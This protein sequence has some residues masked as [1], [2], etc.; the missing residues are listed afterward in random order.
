M[1]QKKKMALSLSLVAMLFAGCGTIVDESSEDVD[2]GKRDINTPIENT[3]VNN[4]PIATSQKIT[5][6]EDGSKTIV[7]SGMDLDSDALTY[8]VIKAPIRG[9]L[10]GLTYIP[11]ADFNG[12]DSF[13]FV[14]NDTTIDSDE[15]TVSIIVNSINDAPTVSAEDNINITE[16]DSFSPTLAYNDIDGYI[17]EENIVWKEDGN[18]ITFPKTDFS[19]GEYNLTVTVTD[20]EGLSATDFLTLI[21]KKPYIP[22]LATGQSISYYANDDGNL[23]KGATRSF[24]RDDAT[25]IVTDNVTKLMWQDDVDSGVKSLEDALIYCTSLTLGGYEDWRLPEIKELI[26]LVDR[27]KNA[28]SVDVA[29]QNFKSNSYQSYTMKNTNEAWYVNFYS[30]TYNYTSWN[31]YTRCVREVE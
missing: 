21:V 29:F 5:L 15:A 11:D 31:L 17:S 28:P 26:Y 3:A 18:I 6:D 25:E 13:T 20:N 22:L 1:I 27:S 23:T 16:G 9:T 30:G 8:R 2:K 7:L 10:D 12:N 14:A 4:A 24:T 19:A